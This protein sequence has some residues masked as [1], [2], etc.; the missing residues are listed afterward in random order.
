DLLKSLASID[1]PKIVRRTAIESMLR[2]RPAMA[3]KEVKSF[4]ETCQDAESDYR[5]AIAIM[6][7][8]LKRRGG[9]KMLL[10]V[11]ESCQLSNRLTAK[12]LDSVRKFRPEGNAIAKLLAEKSNGIS[13][14][15]YTVADIP[16]IVK[17]VNSIG[18]ADLG[19]LVYR[20]P[21]L[22]CMT[23][24]AIGG[25]GGV[26][27]PDMISLGASS[28]IDYIIES[29]LKP[30][31]KIKEGYH[32]TNILTLD[33]LQYSG[34]LIGDADGQL[35]L[36]DANNKLIVVSNEDV[37]EK[38]ISRT[39]LM[40][41]D[42]MNGVSKAEFIHLVAFLS[43][44]GKE[45][46]FKVSNEKLVRRWIQEDETVIYSFVN[47]ELPREIARGKTLSFD[48]EVTNSGTIGF[49][50]ENPDGLRITLDDMKDNLRAKK[51][52]KDMDQGIHRIHIRVLGRNNDPLKVRLIDVEGSQGRAKLVN[53]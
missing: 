24:H 19:E 9:G 28:P 42:L 51:I 13:R 40:P 38:R 31:A 16:E 20:K 47:G 21:R 53:Q 30:S 18:D 15:N 22:N 41:T 39:S 29:L 6:A 49:E 12:L 5:H 35:S 11:V 3:A 52:L 33:G 25:A 4:L 8:F 45:G 23:C 36:R 1:Q 32:T 43:S 27:G 7:T 14:S 50:I 46:R 26:V 48:F 10:P 44:L 2:F 37:E 17:E 34:K